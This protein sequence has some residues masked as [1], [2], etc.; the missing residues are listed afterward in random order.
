MRDPDGLMLLAVA[1]IAVA[2][3]ALVILAFGLVGLW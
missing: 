3:A 1:F 2:L